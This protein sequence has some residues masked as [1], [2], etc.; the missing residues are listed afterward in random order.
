MNEASILKR[1][2]LACSKGR[3]RL[4]RNNVG[5]YQDKQGNW[6]RYGLGNPG[7]SDLIG[8]NQVI[9]TPEHVGKTLAVFTALEVKTPRGILTFGQRRFLSMVHEAGGIADVVR[10][11]EDAQIVISEGVDR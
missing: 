5:Q 3:S 2:M 9:I 1:I 4:F 8:W 6:V 7:G 10:S 11:P